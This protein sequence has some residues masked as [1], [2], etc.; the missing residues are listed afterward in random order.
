MLERFAREE[1]KKTRKKGSNMVSSASISLEDD[2]CV[3]PVPLKRI[4]TWAGS[5]SCWRL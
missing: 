1:K 3:L 2:P 4:K 5:Q